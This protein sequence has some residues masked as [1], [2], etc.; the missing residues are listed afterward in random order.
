MLHPVVEPW[1]FRGW[2]LDFIGEVCPSSSKGHRFVLMATDY[3][4]KWI[5]AMPLRSMTHKEVINFVLQH[6]VHRFWV[7]Q[8]LTTDQGLAFMSH[9]FKEFADSLKIKVLNSSPYYSEVEASNKSIMKLIKKKIEDHLRRWHEV[10]SETLWAY[11]ISK[12]GTIQACRVAKQNALSAEEYGKLM[13][14]NID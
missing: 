13:M 4:T 9:Q 6:I 3:F 1:P 11:R 10:L 7:P 5:E 12:H 8:T 2:D 14:D